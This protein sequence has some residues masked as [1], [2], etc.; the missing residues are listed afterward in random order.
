M[1]DQK[2]MWSRCHAW[3]H[4]TCGQGFGAEIG[5][6]NVFSVT[7][8]RTF[9]EEE[10]KWRQLAHHQL[11]NQPRTSFRVQLK[12]IAKSQISERWYLVV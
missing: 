8:F 3:V 12:P 1:N 6:L 11:M 4:K 9:C 5:I 2:N 7:S 10:L